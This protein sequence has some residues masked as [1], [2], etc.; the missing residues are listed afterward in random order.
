MA[1]F[2]LFFKKNNE[3]HF[4]FYFCLEFFFNKKKGKGGVRPGI[5]SRRLCVH[6]G[7]EIGSMIPYIDRAK[8]TLY[9]RIMF[10]IRMTKKLFFRCKI[11]LYHG[12]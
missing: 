5:W 7:L 6:E 3:F 4:Y 8:V 9:L 10:R 1:F 12:I 11:I 2:F